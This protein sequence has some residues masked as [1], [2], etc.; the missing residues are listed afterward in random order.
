WGLSEPSVVTAWVALTPS[1]RQ[2]GCVRVIPGTHKEGQLQHEDTFASHNMA[3]R[4]QEI[5]VDVDES[6]A[7]EFE[8]QPGEFSLHHTMLVHASV[9]NP[10]DMRR[11]GIPIR[12]IAAHVRQTTGFKDSA[13]LVRGQ[14]THGNF[15]PEPRPA[16]DFDPTAVAFYDGIVAEIRKR[17]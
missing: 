2:N 11:C 9:P 4:G 12:Y 8:L 1:T 17:K 6:K 5:K 10:S 13:T 7:V 15:L 3:S 16:S 14:D